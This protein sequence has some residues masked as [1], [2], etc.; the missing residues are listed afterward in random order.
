MRCDRQPD[1]SD[2]HVLKIGSHV[3]KG[4]LKSELEAAI[5][6]F[7]GRRGRTTGKSRVSDGCLQNNLVANRPVL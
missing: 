5:P 4:K 2:G 1:G 7:V 3:L 6:G